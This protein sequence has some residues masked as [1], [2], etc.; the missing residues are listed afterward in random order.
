MIVTALLYLT[1]QWTQSSVHSPVPPNWLI[2]GPKVLSETEYPN[3]ALDALLVS[4]RSLVNLS[5]FCSTILIVHVCASRVTEARHRR[6][7]KVPDGE[8]SH[9]PRKESRRAYLYVLFTVS[10]TLWILCVKI[11]LAEAKLGIWQ[12]ELIVRTDGKERCLTWCYRHAKRGSRGC[13]AVLS[14]H[15]VYRSSACASRFHPGRAYARLLRCDRF[16]HGDDEPHHRPRKASVHCIREL[17]VHDVIVDLA[18]H[19][20]VYQDLPPPDATTHLSGGTYSRVISHG[21]PSISPAVPFSSPGSTPSPQIKIPG[22]KAKATPS[23]CARIL[24]WDCAHSWG[25]HRTVGEV[26]PWRQRP[27]GV[28]DIL[29]TGREVAVDE[30]RLARLLGCLRQHQRCR[31]ESTA[32]TFEAVSTPAYAGGT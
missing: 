20:S 15:V 1:I 30:A 19:D 25:S 2:E 24:C 31:M 4:R 13:L 11:A 10:V 9:V 32:C 22:R 29:A 23:A 12:G 18:C 26:V 28:G 17:I 8:L 21:I 16:V 27:V 5:T 3:T 7:I 14:V 6:K